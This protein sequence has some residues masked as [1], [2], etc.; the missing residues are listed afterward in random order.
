MQRQPHHLEW[1][2]E[3]T[4]TRR[5]SMRQI[6]LGHPC[7]VHSIDRI[8]IPIRLLPVTHQ[9]SCRRLKAPITT[10]RTCMPQLRMALLIRL[11]TATLSLTRCTN[12]RTQLCREQ[13]RTRD[14]IR[15][16]RYP[17]FCIAGEILLHNIRRKR[18]R[19]R[20]RVVLLLEM[21]HFH[22]V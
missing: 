8:H 9:G 20:N 21:F 3:A 2:T 4:V 6:M 19:Q 11:T 22:E 14:L 12:T 18:V 5:I 17:Q 7:I 16:E 15:S 13:H 1:V 10:L